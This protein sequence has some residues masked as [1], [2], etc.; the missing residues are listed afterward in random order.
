MTASPIDIHHLQKA[1]HQLD[2]ALR[3]W[4]AQPEGSELKPHLRSAVI[5]SFEYTYELATRSLK[6]VLVERAASQGQIADMSFNDQLR[7][8]ADSG[9]L[10]SRADIEAWRGWRTLRN[11]TSHTYD[12]AKAEVVAGSVAR[13]ATDAHS[14][15]VALEA[16]SG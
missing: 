6:R 3:L 13:F 7:V 8:A 9:L 1:L 5:Q 2:D 14:L 12:E 4:H 11:A 16:H 10:R 15:L